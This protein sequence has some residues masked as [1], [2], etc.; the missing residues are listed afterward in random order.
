MKIDGT[1]ETLMAQL[2]S[3]AEQEQK[4]QEGGGWIQRDSAFL[5]TAETTKNLASSLFD[6]SSRP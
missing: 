3:L 6:F 1:Q 2:T 5:N 4:A